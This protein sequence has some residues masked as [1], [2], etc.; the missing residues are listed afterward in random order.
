[1]IETKRNLGDLV[2]RHLML[3]LASHLR[4]CTNALMDPFIAI[5]LLTTWR[6]SHG[7]CNDRIDMKLGEVSMVARNE[8]Q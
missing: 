3:I 6:R 2:R 5:D 4:E 8:G 7:A 1:M